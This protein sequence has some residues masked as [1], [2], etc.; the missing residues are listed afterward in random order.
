M[1]DRPLGCR[2]LPAALSFLARQFDSPAA[3]DIHVQFVVLK[4]NPRPYNF[5]RLR[6]AAQRA[7]A[8]GKIH[9]RLPESFGARPA[10][11]EMGRGSST[12]NKKHPDVLI[13]GARPIEVAP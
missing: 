3:P 8:V 1:H 2:G 10:A 7:A 12:A 5:A 4:I 13:Y 6:N 11:R 9:G